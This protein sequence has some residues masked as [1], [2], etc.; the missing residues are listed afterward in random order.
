ML[1]F[2]RVN[3]FSLLASSKKLVEPTEIYNPIFPNY[4][5]NHFISR[6][7]SLRS[8]CNFITPKN[9]DQNCEVMNQEEE[10]IIPKHVALALDGS[11][12]WHK[13][14]GLDLDYKPFYQGFMRF[15]EYCLKWKVSSA[16]FYV[17]GLRN[18]KKR[19][20]EEVDL[21][22]DQ[23]ETVLEEELEYFTRKG[24]RVL[25]VG[26]KYMLPKSLQATIKKVEEATKDNAKLDLVLPI[27]Y[28]SQSDIVQATRKIC[29]KVKEGSITLEDVNE[30]LIQ[31][32]LAVLG[33]R[34][35]PDL[36]I[37]TGGQLRVGML[38]GWQIANVH[39]HITNTCAPDFGKDVFLDAL[40]SYQKRDTTFGR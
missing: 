32:H 26:E 28:T 21:F 37:R 10:F 16:T 14:H 8:L 6:K 40:R 38:L 11:R 23:L 17:Y 31:Q 18:F 27:C 20:K 1:R 12:T 13:K 5:P 39:L 34:P 15:I 35:I 24:V 9:C 3:G 4:N 2:V 30:D 29:H 25:A 7:N 36:F 19:S 33:S 22:L